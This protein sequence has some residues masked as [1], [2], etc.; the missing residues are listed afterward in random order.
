[1]KISHN[2]IINIHLSFLFQNLTG[3]G[4]ILQPISESD[5]AEISA[6]DSAPDS[7]SNSYFESSY[8]PL[9]GNIMTDRYGYDDTENSIDLDRLVRYLHPT[10]DMNNDDDGFI[11]TLP[12]KRAPNTMSHFLRDRKAALG[13]FLRDRKA[14]GHF[15][16]DR[17]APGNHLSHF[18]RDRKASINHFLRDRKTA[19]LPV[20]DLDVIRQIFANK[21]KKEDISKRELNHLLRDRRTKNIRDKIQN[22][23]RF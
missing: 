15:L 1:M 13:H 23:T 2:F 22:L 21:S 6:T 14:L 4:E 18:L 9:V 16:R 3:I 7:L 5:R 12:E 17:K 20:R 8:N 19:W 10:T 11:D